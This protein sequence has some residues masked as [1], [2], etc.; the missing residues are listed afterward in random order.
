MNL[1][2]VRCQL[3]DE[4]DLDYLFGLL[5]NIFVDYLFVILELCE[6]ILVLLDPGLGVWICVK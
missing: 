2:A 4:G 6:W 5:L 3:C 1:C